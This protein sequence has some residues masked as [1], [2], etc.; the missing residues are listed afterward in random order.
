MATASDD[1]TA[2]SVLLFLPD[3][4]DAVL[5]PRSARDSKISRFT[6]ALN[7]QMGGIQTIPEG[8]TAES[9]GPAVQQI[10]VDCRN[11]TKEEDTLDDKI[12]LSEFVAALG[13]LLSST[14]AA[15]GESLAQIEAQLSTVS[16]F[17]GSTAALESATAADELGSFTKLT[18]ARVVEFAPIRL[19]QVKVG[20]KIACNRRAHRVTPFNDYLSSSG[21]PAGEAF[22]VMGGIQRVLPL[23]GGDYP[24]FVRL[25]DS[26]GGFYHGIGSLY[27]GRVVSDQPISRSIGSEM[28]VT[29]LQ[30]VLRRNN[31]TAYRR[32]PV[33]EVEGRNDD[34]APDSQCYRVYADDGYIKTVRVVSTISRGLPSP[35]IEPIVMFRY[36]TRAADLRPG[37]LIAVNHPSR[38]AIQITTAATMAEDFN[39][40]TPVMS[41]QRIYSIVDTPSKATRAVLHS[42]YIRCEMNRE[43]RFVVAEFKTM[44]G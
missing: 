32:T 3:G 18:R 12:E 41:Y 23:L 35:E 17:A 2:S 38:S 7:D 11:R 14:Q 9:F 16:D 6:R 31:C 28:D 37:D 34:E 26:N 40:D 39:V 29:V 42:G 24:P 36:N 22:T 15:N 25:T 5:P 8:E 4:Y 21:F 43:D 13:F 27:V 1:D 30:G 33:K 10:L 44:G 20:D 19:D